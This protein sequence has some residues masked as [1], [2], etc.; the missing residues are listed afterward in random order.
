MYR[1]PCAVVVITMALCTQAVPARPLDDVRSAKVDAIVHYVMRDRHVRGIE[2]GFSHD[3]VPIYVRGYGSIGVNP[4]RPVNARTVMPIGSL[5]KSFTAAAARILI[6]RGQLYADTPVAPYFQQYAGATGVTLADLLQMRSGI[7][8][9]AGRPGFD[10]SARRPIAP[11]ALFAT[12]DTLP[13]G[14][15]AGSQTEYSNT[16]YLMLALIVQRTARVPYA[17]FLQRDV[18][19]PLALRDTAL[20]QGYSLGFGTAD[21]ESNTDDMLKWLNALD[22][23]TIVRSACTRAPYDNGFFA[24]TFFGRPACYASGY[25][26]GYSSFAARLPNDH[27]DVVLLSNADTV[28]LGPLARSI[29]AIVLGVREAAP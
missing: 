21:L 20:A 17:E 4:A 7:P 23:G 28:D 27:L 19:D 10:R 9:Y 25:V 2:L 15:A 12:I 8:D 6:A 13:L 3:G 11:E 24:A 18:L 22:A 26:A 29:V 5:T 16:N 14:F 1:R